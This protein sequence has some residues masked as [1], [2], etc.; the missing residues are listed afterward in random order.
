[1]KKQIHGNRNMP[2][3]IQTKNGMFHFQTRHSIQLRLVKNVLGYKTDIEALCE[4]TI[5]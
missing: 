3:V 2:L 5:I 4:N 1:M